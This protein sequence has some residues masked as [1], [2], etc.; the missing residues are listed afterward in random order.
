MGLI[1][2]EIAA[3]VVVSLGDNFYNTGVS[4][5]DVE[6]R[7]RSTFDEVSSSPHFLS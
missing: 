7:Y 6:M 4:V 3:Q 5:D 2:E 1:A